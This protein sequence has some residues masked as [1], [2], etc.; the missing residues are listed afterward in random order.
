MKRRYFAIFFIFFFGVILYPWYVNAQAELPIPDSLLSKITYYGLKN[1]SSVLFAHFDKTIYLNNENAWFTAYLLN[2]DKGKSNPTFLSALLV[3][4]NKKT[5]SVEQR[6]IMT[7]GLSFGNILIPDTIPPGDYS[8]ILYTNELRNGKPAGTFTQHITIKATSKSAI[9]ATL[10]IIDTSSLDYHKII[11]MVTDK[12]GRPL[13]DAIV[14]YRI[15]R[16]SGKMKTDHNGQCELLVPVQHSAGDYNIL[17]ADISYKKDTRNVQLVIPF[18]KHKINIKFYPEGGNLV[19]G[20]QSVIGWEAKDTYGMPVK[21]NAVLYKDK[22]PIDTL[23]TDSYG[24]GRF[25]I[26][27]IQSSKYELRVT[28]FNDSI[29]K[30]PLI[31]NKGPVI[32]INNAITKDSL[33]VRLTSKYAGRYYLFIHNYKQPFFFIPVEIGVM[34]KN[35]L[36]NLADI[37]KGLSTVTVLDSLQRPCAERIFFAHY[38]RQIK[39]DITTDKQ[40][41]TTRQKVEL[42]LKLNPQT[43]DAT[44]GM[45]SIACVQSSRMEIRKAN[46]IESYVYLRNE[47]ENIP[48]KENYMEHD[49]ESITYLENVLLIKGWRRYKWKE[50]DKVTTK[51]TAIEIK[52]IPPVEADVNHYGKPSKKSEKVMAMTDSVVSVIQTD[53][54]G[55]FILNEKQVITTPGRKVHL[56]LNDHTNSIKM[57]NIF[58]DLNNQVIKCLEPVYNNL[59]SITSASTDAQ[60][61][62]GFDHAINLKE[63]KIISKKDSQYQT[64]NLDMSEKE[65]LCGDYVCRYNFLNCPIHPHESDNRAPVVGEIYHNHIGGDQVYKGCL[66]IPET[67]MLNVKGISYSQEFYGEDYSI[68]NPSIPEYQSTIFWKHACIVNSQEE[69]TLSFYTSDITGPFKIIIQGITDNDVIYGEKEFNVQKPK[70]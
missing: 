20:T 67:S 35:I 27:P 60:I 62:T 61:I 23:Y 4:D 28:N 24:M 40:E 33:R 10:S 39:A 34:G 38:D 2:Y 29:Y 68:I 15:G 58:D 18:V 43:A 36:I 14:D 55:H 49:S 41:Y 45:V 52:N 1:S 63:V 44:Q 22:R 59:F 46:N 51:D 70:Q 42:K 21:L 26:I 7:D 53:N 48:V 3:N 57:N 50:M 69:T 11:V 12:A 6:F 56:L 17:S 64:S 32:T 30:L 31:L 47:L 5:I 66:V 9:T 19:N 54:V 37:P 65:N 16:I 25:K 8:F 13:P